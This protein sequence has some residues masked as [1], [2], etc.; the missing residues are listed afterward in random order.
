VRRILSRTALLCD[1]DGV[2]DGVA[3]I[4]SPPPRFRFRYDH[5][6]HF[7]HLRH[8]NHR[9]GK[10]NVYSSRQGSLAQP[11]LEPTWIRIKEEKHTCVKPCTYHVLDSCILAMRCGAI[12]YS[13]FITLPYRRTKV[14][15]HF[16]KR[17]GCE[18]Q[19]R[20]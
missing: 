14:S 11:L 8:Q 5:L 2:R 18:K 12:I 15:C 4:G 13:T 3:V 16:Q 19:R 20:R 9:I 6:C 7:P 1:F 17:L 10:G